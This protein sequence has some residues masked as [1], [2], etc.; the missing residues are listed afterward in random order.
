MTRLKLLQWFASGALML[1]FAVLGMFFSA[2]WKRTAD[3]LFGF[4]AAAFFLLAAERLVLVMVSPDHEVHYMVYLV[5]L[6]AFTTLALAIWDRN[7]RPD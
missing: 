6:A 7:R 3:R 5:R 4:F 2:F 1:G